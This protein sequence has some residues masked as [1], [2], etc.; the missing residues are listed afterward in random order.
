MTSISSL[1]AEEG[2]C[3]FH[4]VATRHSVADLFRDGKCCGIYVLHFADDMFYIGQSIDVRKRFLQHKKTY[5]DIAG[6]AFKKV[7][8]YKLDAEEKYYIGLLESQV[9]IRNISH[10]TLPEMADSEIDNIFPVHK[11][12]VWLDNPQSPLECFARVEDDVL[13]SKTA[14]RCEEKLLKDEIF[15]QRVLP[16][17]RE[18]VRKCI[19]EPY[20]TELTFWGCSCLPPYNKHIKIYSRINVRFQEVFTASFDYQI[21]SNNFSF[22]LCKSCLNDKI[23]DQLYSSLPTFGFGYHI[24]ETGGHDQMWIG[25]G[26]PADAMHLLENSSFLMAAKKFNLAR[27]RTGAQPWANYHCPTLADNLLPKVPG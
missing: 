19:P 26:S 1:L 7:A 13:R 22:H 21:K 15:M 5:N 8:K 9:R 23:L 18:Y 27:F 14:K 3:A 10:T 16:V 4:N 6:I 25:V 11:Q 20:L 12:K 17:M 2:F 24:Y